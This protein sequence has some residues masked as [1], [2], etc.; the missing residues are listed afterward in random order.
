MSLLSQRVPTVT[1]ND[2]NMYYEIHGEGEPL[3][4]IGGLSNDVT[5]YTRPSVFVPETETFS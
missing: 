4:L 1:V 2:I 3:V 5:D